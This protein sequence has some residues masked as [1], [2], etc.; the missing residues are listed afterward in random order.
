MA[1]SEAEV[2]FVLYSPF[3]TSRICSVLFYGPLRRLHTGLDLAHSA[4][5]WTIL[6]AWNSSSSVSPP[7]IRFRPQRGTRIAVNHTTIPS[8]HEIFVH[9]QGLNVTLVGTPLELRLIYP[10]R[11]TV[12]PPQRRLHPQTTSPITITAHPSPCSPRSNPQSW[13][14][15]LTP[16]LRRI[17]IPRSRRKPEIPCPPRQPETRPLTSPFNGND[18]PFTVDYNPV[19]QASTLFYNPASARIE[20]RPSSTAHHPSSVVDGPN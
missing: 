9:L 2:L 20:S 12:R 1:Y 15:C 13:K 14:T 19:R 6:P 8:P 11:S 5:H 4:R 18:N 7:R 17:P 10:V 3:V 16:S